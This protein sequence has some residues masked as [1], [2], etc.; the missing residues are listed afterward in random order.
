MEREPLAFRDGRPETHGQDF[1]DKPWVW[2]TFFSI[3]ALIFVGTVW[4]R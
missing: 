4:Y 1:L 3:P 2:W